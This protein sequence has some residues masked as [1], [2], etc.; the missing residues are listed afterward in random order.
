MELSQFPGWRRGQAQIAILAF[1]P[2]CLM[3]PWR[4]SNSNMANLHFI[5]NFKKTQQVW[6]QCHLDLSP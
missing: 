6:K 5:F 2:S 3:I 1:I 4:S